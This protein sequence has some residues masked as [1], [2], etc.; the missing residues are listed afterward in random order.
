MQEPR[1]EVRGSAVVA[2]YKGKSH[3]IY[4]DS[5]R[6]LPRTVPVVGA[7]NRGELFAVFDGIGSAEKGHS[8]AV[9]MADALTGFYTRPKQYKN[10][11]AGVL[12]LLMDANQEINDWGSSPGTGLSLGAC[13]GSIVYIKDGEMAVFHVGDTT[14]ILLSGDDHIVLTKAHQS[15][16]HR[17]LRYF[18]QG[19]RL[20][21][22][23]VTVKVEP[24]DLV[25]M[26]SDG[27]SKLIDAKESLDII[28]RFDDPVQSARALARTA[29]QKGSPDDI[30]VLVAEIP[31]EED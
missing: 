27:I 23:L 9:A 14:A 13:C 26:Y 12:Q 2:W 25:I 21:I 16:P 6:L 7:Q 31:D 30:T 17:I 28:T 8:A 11:A 18:G 19:K 24:Y 4:E 3:R 10:S 22:D 1:L 20:I 15:G 5:F 29:R